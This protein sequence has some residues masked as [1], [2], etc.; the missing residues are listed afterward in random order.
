MEN[1][2]ISPYQIL[3]NIEAYNKEVKAITVRAKARQRAFEKKKEQL[4][5]KVQ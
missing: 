2:Y 1:E 4:L 3:R 5:K